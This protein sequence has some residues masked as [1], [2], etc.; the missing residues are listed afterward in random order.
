MRCMVRCFLFA[1]VVILS[2]CSRLQID[3]GSD[4]EMLDAL[5]LPKVPTTARY[6]VS[7]TGSDN[8]SCSGGAITTPFASIQKAVECV[9]PGDA[10]FLRGGRYFMPTTPEFAAYIYLET[11]GTQTAPITFMSH[12]GEWAILDFS[13][14]KG[15]VDTERIYFAGADW[16][17]FRNLEIYKSPQQGI[18]LEDGAN[19]NYFINLVIK[20]SWGSGFQIYKG[21][22]NLVLCSDAVDSG[23]NNTVDPGNSDGFGSIGQGGPSVDNRFFFNLSQRNADDGFDSWV[24]QRSYFVQNISSNNG[25]NGGNGVGFKLG[26]GPVPNNIFGITTGW[27]T[28]PIR[29]DWYQANGVIRRNIAYGNSAGFE[30]NSGA[31]NVL[32]NNTAWNNDENFVMYK[33]NN[34]PNNTLN[35]LRNNLSYQGGLQYLASIKETTNSWNLGITNPGFVSLNTASANFLALQPGSPAIDKGTILPSTKVYAGVAPDLGAL[36][37]GRQIASLR[38][39]CPKRP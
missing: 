17:V 5:A 21:S 1:V 6:Y 9:Q 31:G 29:S 20:E 38:A 26:P 14:L 19:N 28:A 11:S 23:K 35:T 39:S 16:I 37:L 27:T 10:V 24:S 36:E 25:Y 4:V 22:R 32:D 2:S 13:K 3:D 8:Q 33:N 7:L 15:G 12:P 34:N 18:Y 30:S